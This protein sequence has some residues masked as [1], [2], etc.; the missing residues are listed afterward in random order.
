MLVVGKIVAQSCLSLNKLSHKR[1]CRWINCRTKN[2]P[3]NVLVVGKISHDHISHKN[4]LQ[5]GGSILA[6]NFLKK[7]SK[8]FIA[9]GAGV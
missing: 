5:V 3:T 7:E 4:L 8:F 6:R 1:A 2:C 9:L